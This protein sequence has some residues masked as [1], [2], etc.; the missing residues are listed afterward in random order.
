MSS[1]QNMTIYIA[2]ALIGMLGIILAGIAII[3]GRDVKWRIKKA[4]RQEF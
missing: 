3:K 4:M 1:L 2:Q